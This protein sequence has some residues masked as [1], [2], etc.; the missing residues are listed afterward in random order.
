MASRTPAMVVRVASNIDELR[1]RLKEG[2]DVIDATRAGMER[3]AASF[4][5]DRIIQ[6]AHNVVAAVREIGGVSKLTEAEQARVN[7]TLERALAK[8]A[9]LGQQA[10]SEMR[11][12]ADETR[13]VDTASS[14]LT[15]TVKRLAV[16]F[17]AMFT[18]RA[19]FNFVRQTA[20]EAS[21]LQD[22]AQQTR[23]NAE[24]LQILAGAMS[25][26]GVD[27]DELGR[28]LFMLSRRI[29]GQDDSVSDALK[30]M[31][32]SFKDVQGLNGEELFLAIQRGLASLQGSLRDTTAVELY[33]SKLGMSMAG[34][35]EGAD[36]AVA[37]ARRL[38]TVMSN[39]TVAAL[40][41][42][43]ESI[44]QADKNLRLLAAGMLGPVAEG[45]NVVTNAMFQGASKW[46]LFVAMTK[47]WIASNAV[48][49]ASTEHLTRLL[50]SLNQK[51]DASAKAVQGATAAHV[52]YRPAVEST[53]GSTKRAREETEKLEQANRALEAS[54]AKLMSEVKNANQLAIMEA[55]AAAMVQK[56]R[57]A[58]AGWFQEVQRIAGANK[59]NAEAE[60]VY[61]AEQD[62]LFQE[63][64]KSLGD[65]SKAHTDSG[66]AAKASA[67]Q[68]I[69]GYAGIA[70]QITFT[71]EAVREW[72]NLMRYS[73][74]ANA[75]LR[76]GSSLFTT[77]SQLERVAAL[78]RE[79]GGPVSSGRPYVVGEKGPEL[80]VPS[81]SGTIVPNGGGGTNVSLTI[82]PG[83]V[84]LNYPVM[85][86][87]V[88]KTQLQQMFGGIFMD[89][90]RNAGVA[91]PSGA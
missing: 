51:T 17:A 76:S 86:D 11:K 26:F 54:Y 71:G 44:R 22:L 56:K 1:Q 84:V 23:I 72:L 50:D 28:A 57:D 52:A 25:N 90:L 4:S 32:M 24:T 6:H 18:A 19:A 61:L 12:L 89:A 14:T 46:D 30:Q 62:R 37:A 83:A 2:R 21:A 40:D 70:Q 66:N 75:I 58:A 49:G 82:A 29:A 15:D 27:A 35:A 20:S 8:Y 41:Q 78:P 7:A 39:E 5:G 53:A 16:G 73:A 74:E 79:A 3:L 81:S 55:D 45:F 10:P 87:P 59:A 33:G 68:T 80:F 63:S 91:L 38:N 64:Q 9:A 36:A 42:A 43:D 69:A 67:D 85:N 60:K 13:Q 31:G 65:M 88:A 34:A 47:D 48:T 77:Q